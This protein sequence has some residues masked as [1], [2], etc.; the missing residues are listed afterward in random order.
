MF[1]FRCIILYKKLIFRMNKK[2][3]FCMYKIHNILLIKLTF[4]TLCL[5]E[6]HFKNIDKKILDKGLR[7]PIG[8]HELKDYKHLILFLVHDF[9]SAIICFIFVF[10]WLLEKNSKLH[11]KLGK[12]LLYNTFLVLITGTILIFYIEKDTLH[13]TN[14]NILK[15]IIG[16]QAGT[17]ITTI[18][19]SFY[20][21]K[22]Y[23]K[24]YFKKILLLLHFYNIC[25]IL[26]A[27]YYIFENY[28]NNFEGEIFIELLFMLLIPE[29]LFEY[30]NI[31]IVLTKNYLKKIDKKKH[32]KMNVLFLFILS[33][34]G[35]LF[36]VAHD[37]YWI[38]DFPGI[39]SFYYKLFIEIF[40][41]YGILFYN[42]NFIIDYIKNLKK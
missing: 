42:K 16:T 27:F 17:Y 3:I 4:L 30:I 25:F 39:T 5:C 37:G 14:K 18:I 29:L 28:T 33:I 19:H 2:I 23:L 10:Q 40:P 20:I 22:I 38:W 7:S 15:K 35:I 13:I 41:I 11:I 36:N 21:E 6:S 8:K 12:I 31:Y 9:S 32:H 1:K 26:F 24:P 34:P